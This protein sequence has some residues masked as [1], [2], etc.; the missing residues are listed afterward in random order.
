[1]ITLHLGMPK[2]GTSALQSCAYLATTREV[3]PG[4]EYPIAG[5]G[6]AVA[7]HTLANALRSDGITSSTVMETLKEI[8]TKK[9][10]RH[11]LI[12]SEAFTNIL[13]DHNL[14]HLVSFIE[15]CGGITETRAVLVMRAMDRFMESMYLQSVKSGSVATTIEEYVAKRISRQGRLFAAVS[16]LKRQ[17][18]TRFQV[19]ILTKGFDTISFFVNLLGERGTKLEKYR[20]RADVNERKSWKLQNILLHLDKVSSQTGIELDRAMLLQSAR[21]GDLSFKD[22]S[23]EYRVIPHSLACQVRKAALSAATEHRVEEYIEAFKDIEIM[24]YEH[25][26]LDFDA[27]TKDDIEVI[28]RTITLQR[29]LAS[30]KSTGQ[31]GT[32]PRD[33]HTTA[34]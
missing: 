31:T 7:H 15:R 14:P 28:T 23:I 1:M 24:E 3:N 19:P 26:P 17:F 29:L 20:S 9:T 30:R 34:A 25:K 10:S 16:Q 4:F 27:I 18:G 32:N 12:S 22:D 2:T 8:D 5:R 13:P 11:I 21:R 6:N 33:H